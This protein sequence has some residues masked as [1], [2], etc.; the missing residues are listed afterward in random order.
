M[1]QVHGPRRG[2]T[3]VAVAALLLG[4]F[5]SAHAAL[6]TPACLAKKLGAWAN[7]RKCQAGENGKALQGKA[8][9]AG[10][11]QT[12]FDAKLT[13]ESDKATAAGLP[14]RRQRRRHRDRLRHRAPMGEEDR[15][16]LH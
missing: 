15:R 1:P 14:L 5:A 3:V 11:C 16:G 13:A 10:K 12:K 9:D 7:L 6:T 4:G 2:L 8:A